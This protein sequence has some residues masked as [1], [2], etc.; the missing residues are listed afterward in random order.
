MD[1]RQLL[2]SV[3]VHGAVGEEPHDG[4]PR[5]DSMDRVSTSLVRGDLLRLHVQASCDL[6]MQYQWYFGS[7]R[8]VREEPLPGQNRS[9][10]AVV[11][12]LKTP[13]GH[14]RCKV[15][16]D[17][18]PEG[19]FSRWFFVLMQRRRMGPQKRFFVQVKRS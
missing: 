1:V 7:V 16:T 13:S 12:N 19:V 17:G 3:E 5:F 14:Y 2:T 15:F 8:M 6:P 11:T 9:E 18:C 4:T 10:L